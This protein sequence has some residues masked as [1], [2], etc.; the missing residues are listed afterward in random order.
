MKALRCLMAVVVLAGLLLIGGCNWGNW[1]G[2][3]S[4]DNT[5][6]DTPAQVL[7]NEAEA[8]YNEGDYEEAAEVF[9]QLKDRYPYSRFALLA[10]LRVGDAYYKAGRFDEAV[11]AYDDFVRLHPKNEAVPYALYQMGMV[12]HHQML[13]PSR[14]P[15]M[16]KKARDTFQRL[17]RNYPKSE[18]AIKAKPRLQEATA[19][20]A[21]H[22]MFVGDF[23]LRTKHFRAAI[24]RY[25]R[26][27]TDYPDV[28]LYGKAL[29]Q[30]ETAQ[31]RLAELPPEER[32]KGGVGTGLLDTLTP[33]PEDTGPA[34]L[35][36]GSGGILGPSI[37]SPGGGI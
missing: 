1:F 14:D 13:I 27:L 18:W 16:A 2:G 37:G 17:L 7:A 5:G 31:Q 20:M 15:S 34:I 23:Y 28:G 33:F 22:D 25:K 36:D 24:G 6:F 4:T 11:L 9:Q 35:D 12:Y 19:R 26:V 8:R 30:I 32:K 21:S 3:T 29:N 10:D